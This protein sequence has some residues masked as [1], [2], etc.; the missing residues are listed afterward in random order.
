MGESFILHSRAE[1][2]IDLLSK[3]VLLL[4]RQAAVLERRVAEWALYVKMCWGWPGD[5]VVK[6]ARS[7]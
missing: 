5:I 3:N 1:E 2:N 6:F 4:L 7:T